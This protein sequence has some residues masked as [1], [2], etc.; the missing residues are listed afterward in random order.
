ML[1]RIETYNTFGRY[2]GWGVDI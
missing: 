2:W 1:P